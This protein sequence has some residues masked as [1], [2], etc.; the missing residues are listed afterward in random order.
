MTTLWFLLNQKMHR[1]SS[2]I[3]SAVFMFLYIYIYIEL[4]R[5]WNCKKN[6]TVFQLPPW[7]LALTEATN[8]S[9]GMN[10]LS[11]QGVTT[12]QRGPAQTV[13]EKKPNQTVCE[14]RKS[15]HE[16]CMEAW[17]KVRKM[18]A[19]GTH[20]VD[21]P[22]QW[23]SAYLSLLDGLQRR[24]LDAITV[25]V[26]LHV[27]QHHAGTQQQGRGVG[28]VLP[29]YVWSRA[30][31]LSH[32]TQNLLHRTLTPLS[33][34]AA[35]CRHPLVGLQAKVTFKIRPEQCLLRQLLMVCKAEL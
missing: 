4:A 2:I 31:N 24:F 19:P 28:L 26:K 16:V 3:Q 11:F 7:P 5:T 23:N 30:V 14:V 9:N 32:K 1:L 8:I 15:V 25:L 21:W 18:T 20:S 35:S 6:T 13:S 17:C 27:A 29:S 12:L 10:V 34:Q 33:H 22:T